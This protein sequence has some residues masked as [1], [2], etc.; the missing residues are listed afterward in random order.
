MLT[1]QSTPSLRLDEKP[2][3][4]QALQETWRW[5]QF[6]ELDGLPSKDVSQIVETDDGT[7]WANTAAGLAWFDG[8]QWHSSNC[9]SFTPS[10]GQRLIQPFDSSSVLATGSKLLT[11]FKRDSCR[12]I[13]LRWNATPLHIMASGRKFKGIFV[14]QDQNRNYYTWTGKGEDVESKLLSGPDDLSSRFSESFAAPI[15][16]AT[17]AGL[18][19]LDAQGAKP[20]LEAKRL[21][22]PDQIVGLYIRASAENKNGAGVISLALPQD[23]IGIWE[24]SP[25]YSLRLVPESQGQI[26]RQLAISDSGDVL[27]LYSATEAWFKEDG[28]WASLRPVPSPLRAANS[29]FFDHTGRLWIA[30]ST[31]IQMLQSGQALWS[32]LQYPFPNLKNHLVSLLSTRDGSLWAG[33]SDGITIISPDGSTKQITAI[34]GIRLGIVTGLAQSLDGSIWCS[35]G[36]T[37]N[38][39]FRYFNGSWQHFGPKQGLLET[40]FHRVQADRQG[41]LWALAS[42]GGRKDQAFGVFHFDGQNFSPV[43]PTSS[44]VDLRAYAIATDKTGNTWLATS[45][46]IR[47]FDGKSW[48]HWS[49]SNG[50]KRN[51]IFY[52]MP[53]PKGGV[54]FLDRRNGVGEIDQNGAVHYQTLSQSAKAQSTWEIAE[55]PDSNIWLSTRAGLF[56]NRQGDWSAIGPAA[57]LENP[58]IWPIAFWRNQVCT[59][60]DGSGIFCLTR[61]VLKRPPPKLLLDVPKIDGATAFVSWKVAGFEESV[62]KEGTVAR[63]RLDSGPWSPWLTIPSVTL[64]NLNQ[65]NH[66]IELQAKDQF[67]NL[68]REYTSTTLTVA[69]PF[70]VQPVF[71]IPIGLSLIAA[72]GAIYAFISRTYHHNRQLA[73]KEESFRALIEYSSV[74]ITLWDRNRRI[75]YASPALKIILGYEPEELLGDFRPDLVHPEDLPAAQSRLTN[76]VEVPGQ[77]QRSRVRMKHKNGEY[78]WIEV[79]SRNLFDNPSVGAIVTNMRDITD[80]TVAEVVAAEA[81]ERAERANQAKSD[82]L[83]MISHEIRTPMNGITGMSQLLLETRLDKDQ[84]DYTETIAQSAHSLLALINDVLDFSRIEAGKLSIERAPI[85]LSY[86]LNEV[87]SLMRV[88]AAEKDLVLKIEYPPDAPRAFYGDALR[89]RQ[90]LFNLTGNAVKFTHQGEV[91]LEVNIH[92]ESG[93]NYSISINVRD[94]GIGIAQDKLQLVFQK[95]T[96]ADLSTTRRYG[97]TGLGLSISRSLAELMGGSIEATSTPGL[98][99]EFRLSIHLDAAPENSLQRKDSSVEALK[100]LAESLDVLLVEDN[101]VNQ[102]LAM[103]LLERLGCKARLAASGIEALAM[104]DK[105]NFDLI[106]MDCQM[107]EMDG[108]EATM[109]IREREHGNQHIPIIAITANS[110]ESDLERCLVSGMDSYLTKPIDFMKLRNAL[111]TWGIDYRAPKAT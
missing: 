8:F 102:K 109:K 105:H 111:E 35:S 78:R 80:A 34:N 63:Y 44:K 59:G 42:G 70:Y 37:F 54:Y 110:M 27:A 94:T 41:H 25:Q 14:L 49:N 1:A 39:V 9:P 52:L 69:S 20:V 83:A 50:L 108:Y 11:I 97:G 104:L 18:I 101:K 13:Q 81:R 60:A 17:Q 19:K 31:G 77:T 87:V 6:G 53:R 76:L 32:R 88:R 73:E 107:P 99:S 71:L 90:I 48:R 28:K 16:A 75:F 5:V 98:G 82:F 66:K 23:W 93:S 24:W 22:N 26:A 68:S 84:Q 74:G 33:S 58:E 10:A 86:L 51:E 47:R 30:T 95:F 29:L 100:P 55:D 57:G 106:L 65:G 21:N 103:R 89:I 36:A 40:R 72:I 91:C 56:V 3:L 61:D 64:A 62:T 4:S 96:Q 12:Q 67:G 85:D 92:W 46:G 7:I 43:N 2:K 79:I 45:T 15:F 38:G